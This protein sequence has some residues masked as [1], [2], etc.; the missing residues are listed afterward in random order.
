MENYKKIGWSLVIPIMLTLL[1]VVLGYI[2]FDTVFPDYPFLRKL[3][4]S[5]QL[6]SMESGDRFY[7]TGKTY[8]VATM[9]IYNAARFLAIFTLIYTIVLAFLSVIKERFYYSRVKKMHGHTILCG[10]GELGNIIAG[11]FEPKKKL[12][13]IEKDT[14]NENLAQLRKQGVKIICGNALDPEVLKR[15]GIEHADYLYALAG[16]D[17]DNLTI[18]KNAR[19]AV[20]DLPAGKDGLTMAGNIDSLNL[21]KT[22]Y[23]EMDDSAEDKISELRNLLDSFHEKAIAIANQTINTDIKDELTKEFESLKTRL[24]TYNPSG[25]LKI[26]A[27]DYK[28]K[29]FNINELGA[30]YI[31][32]QY[33]PDRFVPVS[34]V[35]APPVHILLLGYSQMG[36]ELFKLCVQNCHYINGKNTRIT[37]LY[38]D[39]GFAENKILTKHKNITK[40]IDLHFVNLNPHHLTP[41]SL[42]ENGLTS[43]GVIYICSEQDRTQASY[44]RTA[45]EVFGKCVPIVTWFFREK[46]FGGSNRE[47]VNI[48]TV[49]ILK[50]A[51]THQNII[52]EAIDYK[53]IAIHN[54]W[55]KRAISD[56][57]AQV[58]KNIKD[59]QEIALPKS[60]LLPWHLLD[61]EIR[62]D[63]RSVVEHNLIKLR[64]VGQITDPALY[65][66][67]EVSL[68]DFSF[69]SD[70]VIVSQLAGMEHRRW[71]ANKYFNAWEYCA[72]RND[73]KKHHNDL[74]EFDELDQD[75]KEYDIKQVKE[76][77]E[78]WELKY[79]AP[80]KVISRRYR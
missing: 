14:S 61:E 69:L 24:M 1:T 28:V 44:T 54:G 68:V 64:S 53:A 8:C 46:V 73:P 26:F 62:D 30:R 49:E 15:V 76:L 36:E 11:N 43:V 40:L 6:F 19:A 33:P 2:S 80:P 5:F 48:Y 34:N 45:R 74:K 57:V 63:N 72:V 18:L 3:Y 55:L 65:L 71:M 32:R 60:T 52:D 58:E 12:V 41:G 17:F 50:S 20:M 75:T 9:I 51:A 23:Q 70:D 77:K 56:Y 29:L 4:Y 47:S 42:T 67:P 39:A 21:K 22:A 13:I 66:N 25:N 35:Q 79:E 10:L 31:F 16:D 59:K 38:Q 37:I 7:E 78:V 27:P